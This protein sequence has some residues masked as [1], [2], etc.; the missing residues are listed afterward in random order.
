MAGG[1]QKS[2]GC[3]VGKFGVRRVG[4]GGVEELR[5]GG[6]GSAELWLGG[7]VRNVRVRGIEVGG[8]ESGELG[9]E[10]WLGV[11][12]ESEELGSGGV[13]LGVGEVGIEG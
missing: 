7:G 1:G 2:W 11:G 10:L 6:F 5:V 12:S 13:E 4:I 8:L 3:G 9:L